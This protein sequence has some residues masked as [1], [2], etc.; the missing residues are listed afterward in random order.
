MTM[1][2]ITCIM[3]I[4]TVTRAMITSV[5]ITTTVI[6]TMGTTI[7]TTRAR[8]APPAAIPTRRTRR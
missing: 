5:T 4:P 2:T 6:M 3:I 8:S 7:T 1:A